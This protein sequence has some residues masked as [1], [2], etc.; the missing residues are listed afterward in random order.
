MVY[1]MGLKETAAA[2]E[3]KWVAEQHGDWMANVSEKT[4]RE[5]TLLIRDALPAPLAAD[6][7]TPRRLDG[8]FCGH[9]KWGI[10][11]GADLPYVGS[12][13]HVGVDKFAAYV[14]VG[15]G[16][17]TNDAATPAEAATW[18]VQQLEADHEQ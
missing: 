4:A 13:E 8:K 1:G 15:D 5:F 7:L 9:L 2:V 12:I 16:C 3:A 18:I 17:F 10:R 6:P 11:D 14:F